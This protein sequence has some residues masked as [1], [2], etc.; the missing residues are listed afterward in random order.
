M[1]TT[2]SGRG[3]RLT[4][5]VGLGTVPNKAGQLVGCGKPD[6]IGPGRDESL[7]M[8]SNDGDNSE[9]KGPDEI[10]EGITRLVMR[11]GVGT[12]ELEHHQTTI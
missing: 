7:R 2:A 4:E 6:S 5:R 1:G 9:S 12:F 11:T 10:S 3:G 8:G